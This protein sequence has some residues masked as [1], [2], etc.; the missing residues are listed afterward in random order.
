MRAAGIFVLLVALAACRT[1]TVRQAPTIAN[2]HPLFGPVIGEEVIA[3]RADDEGDVVLL[4]GG[5][6]L[7]RLDPLRRQV[8]R[9]PLAIAPGQECWGL[10]RLTSG[11]LFTIEGRHTLARLDRAGHIV[12]R[13]TL[14]AAHFGLVSAG[15]RLAYQEA[16]FTPPGPA[17][18]VE[19][20]DGSR[21]AW[22][23]IATRTFPH[24]ARASVAALN[25]I[26]C[27]AS[28]TAEHACWFPDEDAVFL[29][30]DNGDTRRVQAAGLEIVPPEM[31]LT[32]DNPRRP[33]RDAYVDAGGRIWIL[34]RGAPPAG[35]AEVPGG[36]IVA[37][38]DADGKTRGQA[39]LS[40]AARLIVRVDARRILLLLSSGKVGEVARW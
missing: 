29:V 8:A 1:G 17:L 15:D 23:A 38:Y 6:E 2:V 14:A 30:K 22:S 31:L 12:A 39:R 16:D 36:W 5:T 18:R 35:R 13:T 28:A 37:S 34:S 10:A 7:V 9:T 11:A 21:S 20:A 25:M 26:S 32:S 27:G 19:A 3:G 40:E 24:L 4:M 33:V